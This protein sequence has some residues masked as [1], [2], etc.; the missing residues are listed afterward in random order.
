MMFRCSFDK[1][2]L[3]IG[4]VVVQTK[5]GG[6]AEEEHIGSQG[7]GQSDLIGPEIGNWFAQSHS[8]AP[9]TRFTRSHLQAWQN[10]MGICLTMF[11]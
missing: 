10:T 1:Q 5:E 9:G 6:H 11:L 3:E 4:E 2:K 8:I 7:F